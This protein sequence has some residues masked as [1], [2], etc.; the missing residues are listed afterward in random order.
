MIEPGRCYSAHPVQLLVSVVDIV[1][2]FKYS[3]SEFNQSNKYLI[4][5]LGVLIRILI[6]PGGDQQHHQ[7]PMCHAQYDSGHRANP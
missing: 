7:Y 2:A 1:L 5:P 3:N 6:V 4:I